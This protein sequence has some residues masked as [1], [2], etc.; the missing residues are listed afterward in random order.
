VAVQWLNRA[1]H[2]YQSLCLVE[3]GVPRNRYLRGSSKPFLPMSSSIIEIG[4]IVKLK[5]A[6]F[7]NYF[8]DNNF[9]EWDISNLY[10]F[11]FKYV[12]LWFRNL[13]TRA[14][15][16]K[17]YFDSVCSSVV[18]IENDDEGN[19]LFIQTEFFWIILPDALSAN[20]IEVFKDDNYKVDEISKKVIED[21]EW[22]ETEY[23]N[24]NFEIL[25]RENN[26]LDFYKYGYSRMRWEKRWL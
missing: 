25:E 9:P 18:R 1:L 23:L 4:N 21:L 19:P 11:E 20:E 15:N 16:V 22:I 24:G 8:N 7:R 2:F 14:D 3:S 12:T 10:K 17:G 26:K 6:S 13:K 5:N